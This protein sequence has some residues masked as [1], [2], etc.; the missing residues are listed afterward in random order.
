MCIIIYSAWPLHSIHTVNKFIQQLLSI[1]LPFH[2][3]AEFFGRTLWLQ[4]KQWKTFPNLPN[5]VKTVENIA[6]LAKLCLQRNSMSKYIFRLYLS[7][8]SLHTAFNYMPWS[9]QMMAHNRKLSKAVACENL[10]DEMVWI[11][12]AKW[13]K[14]KKNWTASELLAYDSNASVEQDKSYRIAGYIHEADKHI[15]DRVP[16]LSIPISDLCQRATKDMLLTM[17]Q[18]HGALTSRKHI[19]LSRIVHIL[20]LHSCNDCPVLLTV[21]EPNKHALTPTERK[22][23]YNAKHTEQLKLNKNQVAR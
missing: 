1:H 4:W 2:F 19:E 5:S 13:Y 3:I 20:T 11:G 8:T 14:P 21:F 10:G 18:K 7:H 12:G 23:I 22:K 9:V 6:K 15:F 16:C 17:A